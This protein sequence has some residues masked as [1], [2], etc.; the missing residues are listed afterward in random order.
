VYI[1]QQDLDQNKQLVTTGACTP[2]DVNNAVTALAEANAAV[3]ERK[4][5]AAKAA[6]AD[7]L[8]TWNQD[9]LSLS[10]DLS[11]LDAR[12]DALQKRLKTL[13][14]VLPQLEAQSSLKSHETNLEG[15]QSQLADLQT[16]MAQLTNNLSEKNMP[17]LVVVESHDEPAKN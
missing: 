6:G 1:L 3:L 16:L 2:G 5:S 11:E 7:T 14:D 10:I 17:K 8:A 13:G 4:E 9:L 15:I 12:S